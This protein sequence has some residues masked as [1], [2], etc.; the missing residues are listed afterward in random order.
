MRLSAEDLRALEVRG[1]LF[2]L[3]VRRTRLLAFG[4]YG[5]VLHP[6]AKTLNAKP[7]LF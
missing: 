5:G 3:R 1:A 7:L 2:H 4:V 6:E